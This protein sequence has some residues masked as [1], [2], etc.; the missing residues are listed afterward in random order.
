[1]ASVLWDYDVGDLCEEVRGICIILFILY[2]VSIIDQ[3]QCLVETTDMTLW[4]IGTY[5]TVYPF[6]I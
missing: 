6:I 5:I 3:Y 1:M 4:K 2:H